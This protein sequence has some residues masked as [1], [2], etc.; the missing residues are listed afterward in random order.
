MCTSY[1]STNP[2][3]AAEAFSL[4]PEPD[5]DYPHEIY[6]DYVGPIFRGREGA[7][8]TDPATFGLVPRKRIRPGIKLFDTMNARAETVGER[9]NFKG[10]WRRLQFCLVPC[11]TFY[12]PNYE[13]GRAVRW[14]IGLADGAPLLVAGLWREWDTTKDAQPKDGDDA[15]ASES[16]TE[17]A[18]AADGGAE[19]GEP[20]DGEGAQ[21]TGD[22]RRAQRDFRALGALRDGKAYSFTMLTVNAD[23]HPLMRRFH[24]PTDEK[25]SLVIVPPT[26]YES[27][28]NCQSTEEARSFLRLYPAELMHAE[29]YPLPPRKPT[30]KQA[31]AAPAKTQTDLF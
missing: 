29:P 10:A 17:E 12:E 8:T 11:R 25:R 9:H 21:G 19:T 30:K 5:F 27:W 20:G 15:S 6:K 23:E 1:E 18:T 7:Y 16:E 4:F 24:R 28:L 14:R 2:N 22:F 31:G 13:T 26:E 3:D